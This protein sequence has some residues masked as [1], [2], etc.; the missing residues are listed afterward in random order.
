MSNTIC[1]VKWLKN[2]IEL[3]KC[4]VAYYGSNATVKHKEY[5][6]QAISS[7][8]DQFP[9]EMTDYLC[10]NNNAHHGFQHL[11][12]QKYI[13]LLEKDLPFFITKNKKKIKIDSLLN[14][15][16]C[17]FDGISN[18]TSIISEALTIPNETIEFYIGG[19]QG[20]YAKPYYLGKLLD[21]IN[22]NDNQSILCSVKKYSFNKIYLQNIDPGIPVKVIHLRIPPHYQMGGMVYVNRVLKLLVEEIKKSSIEEVCP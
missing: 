11:I 21:V 8:L 20:A 12:F 15:H 6:Y 16:L 1:S 9:Q 17:L 18:Y 3:Q 4:S 2:I 22:L 5:V 7:L 10:R 13:A 14:E 19:R